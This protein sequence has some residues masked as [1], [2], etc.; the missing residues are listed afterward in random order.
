MTE[1]GDMAQE[2][3]D[4][5]GDSPGA[6]RDHPGIKRIME[7]V[8]NVEVLATPSQ[9]KPHDAGET[10]PDEPPR[11]PPGDKGGGDE[12]EREHLDLELAF[13]PMTDLGNA[14]RFTAR[15][16]NRLLYCPAFGWA[17]WD[18]K[19]WAKGGSEEVVKRGEHETAR[20]IQD[21][22]RALRESGRDFEIT[23][24]RG[25]NV[26][27]SE[28]LAAWGRVSEGANHLGAISKRA[29]A[30]LAIGV[31]E[32]DADKMVFNVTNGT[33]IIR[34]T[35]DG[36]PYITL[37][38]HD[39]AD[40]ISKISPVAYDSDAICPRFN[41]FMDEVHPPGEDGS[42]RAM[43]HFLDQWAGYSLTGDT[44]E[45]KFTFHFGKGR[46]G[47][48]VWSGT[49][50]H[51]AGDYADAIPIESFLDSGKAR[52]GGQAT[53]DLADLPGVRTLMTSEPKKAAKMDE[54]FIKLFTGGD[55]IKARHLNRDFF[56]F[57]PSAKLT[58]QGNYRPSIGDTDEGLWNRLLLVPWGQYFPPERQDPL[59]AE[60]L[61]AEASGILNRLLDG[62]CSWLDD[63]LAIPASI[64]QATAD[65]RDDS[66][67]LGRFLASCTRQELG[68]RVQSSQ[69]HEVFVAWAR[70]NG[71]KPWSMKGF[72][73]AMKDK[74]IAQIKSV[75][76]Y[77]LDIALT[78]TVGDF[79]D[80]ASQPATMEESP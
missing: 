72:G 8:R 58:M 12:P 62:L 54:A 65:Y 29:C 2:A 48:G 27:Y 38:P 42:G 66:D 77:W 61:R 11:E 60:K 24:A 52:A 20:A 4:T 31:E 35:D 53:P 1:P 43:Q 25:K 10:P 7:A 45:Q 56:G 5:P 22:A 79:V 34:K 51:I 71:E 69:M 40:L 55:R 73:A 75:N 3:Q 17:A 64:R 32:L 70:A 50:M 18:G 68:A 78:K 15:F 28:R 14:E 16:R 46:N 49:L 47:K 21:E 37:K 26:L 39:P 6:A 44:R 33:L 57:V 13:L 76:N 30:N 63:G 19:R 9:A 80:H 23:D 36:S 59:L 74:G 41:Q 67:P